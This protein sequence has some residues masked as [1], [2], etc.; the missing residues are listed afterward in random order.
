MVTN[1]ESKFLRV[2][3]LERWDKIAAFVG[4][5]KRVGDEDSISIYHVELIGAT[6][7]GAIINIWENEKSTLHHVW[8]PSDCGEW[9][10][11]D[12]VHFM[13]FVNAKEEF[14]NIETATD[15]I[16]LMWRNM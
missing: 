1:G 11:R 2:S 12:E 8:T 13:E 6:D 14:E 9:C 7:R 3:E 10:K 16:N 5:S 4:F 15:A